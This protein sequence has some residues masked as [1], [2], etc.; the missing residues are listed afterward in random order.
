[1][2]IENRY[3]KWHKTGDKTNNKKE[4]KSINI[5]DL[6]MP[7]LSSYMLMICQQG[8]DRSQ[9]LGKGESFPMPWGGKFDQ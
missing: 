9:L 4:N 2:N 7:L 3:S 8:R 5:I 6:H 1:M